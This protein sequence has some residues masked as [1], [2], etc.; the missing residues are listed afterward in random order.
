MRVRRFVINLDRRPDRLSDFL[1]RY[2]SLDVERFPAVEGRDVLAS[3][4]HEDL[5]E[6]LRR[7]KLGSV[8][9]AGVLGCWLSHLQLWRFLERSTYDAFVIFED[10]AFMVPLFKSKLNNVLNDL[11]DLNFDSIDVLYFGGRF[12]EGF[13]PKSLDNW[14][15]VGKFFKPKR[16]KLGPE[17]DR[18][19]HGY[20][21]TRRGAKSILKLYEESIGMDRGLPAIDGWLNEQRLNLVSL[22]VFPHLAYSPANY[23]SDIQ[24]R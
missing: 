17:L 9:F 11:N 18:T 5:V 24:V 4:A 10:D 20:I 23:Q 16:L 22:D 6:S 12:R 19:T 14:E 21:V 8:Q 3:G 13:S 2:Q 1:E 7:R 15:G